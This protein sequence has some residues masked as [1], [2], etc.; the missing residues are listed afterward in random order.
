MLTVKIV[1]SGQHPVAL[2]HGQGSD[3][4][5]QN[6]VQ[7]FCADLGHAILSRRRLAACARSAREKVLARI[8]REN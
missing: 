2:I 4:F 8:P 3:V 5:V 1:A 6:F 7:N